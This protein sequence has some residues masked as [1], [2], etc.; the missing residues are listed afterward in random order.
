MRGSQSRSPLS[1]TFSIGLSAKVSHGTAPMSLFSVVFLLL[2]TR[3]LS[4]DGD[5]VTG[6]RPISVN[7]T[8]ASFSIT[9]SYGYGIHLTNYAYGVHCE[10]V[11][12]TNKGTSPSLVLEG[13]T[14]VNK[15]DQFGNYT[16]YVFHWNGGVHLKSFQWNTA[17][18]A[19]IDFPAAIFRQESPDGCQKMSVVN[20]DTASKGILEISSAFPS[21]LLKL[22]GN[23]VEEP[24]PMNY[25]FFSDSNLGGT[26]LGHFWDS[27][28]KGGTHGGLPIVFYDQ[29]L[30]EAVVFSPIDSF[31][32]TILVESETFDKQLAFGLNGKMAE[33]PNG[34]IV[35]SVAFFS[36][37]GV[38]GAMRGWGD[39]LLQIYGKTRLKGDENLALRKL[40]YATDNG[41][42]YY[43]N[44]IPGKNYED[45]M[46]DV[47]KYYRDS[48]LPLSYLQLD[49][50]WYP[51]SDAP[52]DGGCLVWEP[53]P[54]VFPHGMK[55]L[56]KPLWLHS[57]YFSPLSPYR[58]RYPN[59]A[60]DSPAHPCL[61]LLDEKFY[62]DI[63]SNGNWTPEPGLIIYEQDWM[64]MPLIRM[65]VTHSNY[66]VGMEWLQFMNAGAET[67]HTWIQWDTAFPSQIMFSAKVSRVSHGSAG[68]DYQP[69]NSQWDDGLSNMLFDAV[70]IKPWKDTFWTTEKQPGCPASYS[71]CNG[72]FEP[73]PE[74]QTL[75]AVLSTGPVAPGD[76]VGH[77]NIS[78]LRRTCMS[79][80][81]ILKPDRPPLPSNGIFDPSFGSL[82]WPRVLV[83]E[84]EL[85]VVNSS[86]KW[87]YVFAQ[88]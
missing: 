43:Y 83:A 58:E 28:F 10:G 27:E 11:W 17:I 33:L 59:V 7:V 63:M 74:M 44:P 23:A 19:Y 36:N 49:S 52:G 67:A 42:Y 46:L 25:L 88:D 8:D 50:W 5:S 56:D 48:G 84:A 35:S 45:T 60:S 14:M 34:Y 4:C 76:A 47:I 22:G 61:L 41:A 87:Y 3:F 38:R 57:R 85:D 2:T 21:F 24:N 40:G 70:G 65:N 29:Y 75:L 13:H 39:M 37:Q 53:L 12:L 55:I 30:H 79:D 72:C 26:G 62:D 82:N 73:N 54:S 31:L 32:E 18:R 64:S 68:P 6:Y 9:V 1:V 66:S 77:S 80:G 51:K 86:F 78:L 71:H 69:G 20:G 16:E 81:T 15:S